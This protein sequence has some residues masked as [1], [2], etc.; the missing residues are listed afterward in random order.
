MA[1]LAE[2]SGETQTFSETVDRLLTQAPGWPEAHAL[3]DASSESDHLYA[4]LAPK[5]GRIADLH[6]LREGSCSVCEYR[7]R[8]W[9]RWL[10]NDTIR[11]WRSS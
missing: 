3:S 8:T 1:D 6:V 11:K 5:L 7:G 10:N 9:L 2:L 4:E